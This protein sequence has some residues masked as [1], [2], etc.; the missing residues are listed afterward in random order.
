MEIYFD[1]RTVRELRNAAGDA[2]EDGD[3]DAL[4]EDIVRAFSDEQIDDIEKRLSSGD[5]PE[6]I[7][8]ILEE[9]GM[10]DIDNLFE[11]LETHFAEIDIELRLEEVRADEDEEDEEEDITEDEV[12][13]SVEGD[14]EPLEE[15]EEEED[16]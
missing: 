6:F 13:K 1:R 7:G 8:E 15:E 14:E 3:Y 12:E 11:L 5:F 4:A 10:D 9:W 2:I 16:H